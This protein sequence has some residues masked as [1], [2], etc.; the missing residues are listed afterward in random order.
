MSDLM[1]F[2][3]IQKFPKINFRLCIKNN[4]DIYL[5]NSGTKINKINFPF[6]S[7]T[8]FLFLKNSIKDEFNFMPSFIND[9][10]LSKLIL[11]NLNVKIP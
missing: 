6:S 10:E 9:Y 1:T 2:S 7:K 3:I 11:K 5:Y 4:N 8:S